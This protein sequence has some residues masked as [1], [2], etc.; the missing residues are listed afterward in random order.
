M[1]FCALFIIAGL[2]VAFA[3]FYLY[4]K[5]EQAIDSMF[6]EALSLGCKM[7]SDITKKIVGSKKK[8]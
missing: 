5:N 7:K 2:P 3:A 8:D 1:W 4:E 6:L